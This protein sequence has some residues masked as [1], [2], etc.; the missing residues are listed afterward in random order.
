MSLKE[1]S[2]IKNGLLVLRP[3]KQR[4]EI[5][6]AKPPMPE[7]IKPS[8]HKRDPDAKMDNPKLAALSDK[9]MDDKGCEIDRRCFCLVTGDSEDPKSN[10]FALSASVNVFDDH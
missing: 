9:F 10:A 8:T 4:S 2:T 5:S 1:L 3:G 6:T 7:I